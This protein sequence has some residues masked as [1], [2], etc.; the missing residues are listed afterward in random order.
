MSNKVNHSK[1]LRAGK[2][3]FC[4]RQK[5]HLRSNSKRFLVTAVW[6]K[7][8]KFW[9]GII[10]SFQARCTYVQDDPGSCLSWAC[11]WISS[12]ENAVFYLS[13]RLVGACLVKVWQQRRLGVVLGIYANTNN[14]IGSP[15]QANQELVKYGGMCNAST[16]WA[17]AHFHQRK[18]FCLNFAIFSLAFVCH[19][20]PSS[21]QKSSL[22]TQ[23]TC[24]SFSLFLT[25]LPRRIFPVH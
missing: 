8:F 19:S 15:F 17:V 21:W 1:S 22:E 14:V 10:S 20:L 2:Q 23:E 7:C 3:V 16:Q 4:R 11:H 9:Q 12:E 13:V 5:H 24:N 25:T 18:S 6:I